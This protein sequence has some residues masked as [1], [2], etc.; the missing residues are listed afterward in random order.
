MMLT[1][2]CPCRQTRISQQGMVV[3]EDIQMYVC[4]NRNMNLIKTIMFIHTLKDY[5]K[6]LLEPFICLQQPGGGVPG[7]MNAIL[8]MHA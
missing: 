2:A 1:H 6:L 5:P 3:T 4:I 7:I 8:C